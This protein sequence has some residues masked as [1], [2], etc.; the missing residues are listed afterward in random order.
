MA[1]ALTATLRADITQFE[2]AIQ[3]A[4][5]KISGLQKSTS[6]VNRELAKFGN[7]FGGANLIRQANS[8]A[9]AVEDIGGVTKLTTAEQRRLA[10]TVDEALAK[11]RALGQE[12]PP[13]LVSI[14][15]ELGKI[16]AANEAA[17]RSAKELAEAQKRAARET[18]T[19]LKESSGGF[20]AI[21]S[22]LKGLGPTI[23]ATF[24]IGAITGFAKEIINLGGEITDL[25]DR[26][27]LSIEEVQELKYAADQTGASIDDVAKATEK[28]GAK[29]AAG[30]RSALQAVTRL[31]L[32]FNELRQSSPA[33]AFTKVADAIGQVPDPME[34]SRLAMELFG[35]SGVE[36]LPAMSAGFGQL[37]E[38]ARKFGQVLRD[39]TAKALDEFGDKFDRFSQAAKVAGAEAA[40]ALIDGFQ[41]KTGVLKNLIDQ[42]ARDGFGAGG[43]SGA[44]GRAIASTS[45]AVGNRRTSDIQLP[46]ESAAEP[47]IS[48]TRA[49][50]EAEKALA[51]LD[52]AQKREIAT[53]AKLGTSNADIAATLNNLNQGLG[54]TETAVKLY[55]DR[56]KAAEQAGK[57]GLI[58]TLQKQAEE[59]RKLAADIQR[60]GG[61]TKLDADQRAAANKTLLAGVNAYRALGQSVTPAAR[62][63]HEMFRATTSVVEPFRKA[64]NAIQQIVSNIKKLNA[65]TLEPWER[66]T[67]TIITGSAGINAGLVSG[68]ERMVKELPKLEDPAKS[69]ERAIKAARQEIKDSE[70][71]TAQWQGTLGNLANAFGTLAQIGGGSLDGILGKV[72]QLVGLMNAGSQAGAG[73]AKVFGRGAFNGQTLSLAGFRNEKGQFTAGSVAGGGAQA[74]AAGVSAYGALDAATNVKGRGSRV[75]G[76]AATGASIGGQIAGPYGALAGLAI[77]ALIGAFRNPAFE[78]VYKRVAKNFGVELSDETAKAIANL[79]K[80]TFKGDRAAAEIFSLDKIIAEGGGLKQG[81]F[82]VLTQRLRD[83]FSMTEVGKFSADQLTDVLRQNF[84]TFAAY[85]EQSTDLI[86]HKFSEIARLAKA[87]GLDLPEIKQFIGGQTARVGGS[88]EALANPLIQQ[89]ETLRQAQ[90]DL[91]GLLGER[92]ALKGQGNLSDSQQQQL[93]ALEEQIRKT[94]SAIDDN[95]TALEGAQAEFDRLGVIAV[96]AFN[97]ARASGLGFLEATD[98]LGPG[99]DKLIGLQQELGLSGGEAFAELSK[100]RDLVGANEGLVASAEGLGEALL[101]LTNIGGLTK[102][103]LAALEGQGLQTFDRLTAAGFSQ[104]QAIEI[105]R[106]FIDNLREA[107]RQLGVPIDENTQAL[108]D[109][110]AALEGLGPKSPAQAMEQG[111][112]RVVDALNRV[113]K[114]LG[115]DIPEAAEQAAISV[116]GSTSH[117]AKAAQDAYNAISQAGGQAWQDFEREATRSQQEAEQAIRESTEQGTKHYGVFAEKAEDSTEDA[118]KATER[119]WNNCWIQQEE[120]LQDSADGLRNFV[121]EANEA[122]A[123]IARHV[124]IELSYRQGDIPAPPNGGGDVPGLAFGGIVRARAGGTLVRVGEGGRDEAVIPLP[125]GPGQSVT[126]PMLVAALKQIQFTGTLEGRPVLRYV[127]R[128]IGDY[129]QTRTGQRVPI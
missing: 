53:A 73:L 38:D 76:G 107:H 103:T 23:A 32:S 36:L 52:A 83:A 72:A 54:L 10:S 5:T 86:G 118:A 116:E 79:A 91:P 12:V 39:D 66:F 17:E 37:R 4:E 106:G 102:E 78:D 129:I 3:Q 87:A 85:V 121:D 56:L 30:D 34:R 61:V 70:A 117:L 43:L 20:G 127:S 48:Y 101:G 82:D 68:I 6:Q 104:N 122:L 69:F 92:D 46:F 16:R 60:L 113:A 94:Q 51:K 109:Q 59:A 42:I 25:A 111:F 18:T 62:A 11:Y 50:E 97:A 112:D 49:L 21:G 105:M 57:S 115:I 44:L 27:G 74:F 22:A 24:S 55:I 126:V 45:A 119:F 40:L 108:I 75:L 114:G 67:S 95:G 9:K 64:D 80:T 35:K 1:T 96:G 19:A 15:T 90:A 41:N 110:A 13:R 100:F 58:A 128:E 2:R 71:A 123:Q 124:E 125:H 88:L 7:E 93:A 29:L 14:S 26:T 31:G 99:L 65:P 89:L 28:L 33:D 84:G 120:T 77:G 47:V 8:M 63:V 81:N 98:Q